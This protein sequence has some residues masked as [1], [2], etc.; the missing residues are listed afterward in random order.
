MRIAL[1][2]ACF[3]LVTAVLARAALGAD[4]APGGDQVLVLDNERTLEG[5][6]EQIGGQYRLRRP[7]GEL[8][9][10]GE[11][12]LKVCKSRD[13]AYLF[14]KTRANLRDPDERLRLARWCYLNGLRQQALAEVTAAVELRPNHAESRLLL[15]NLQQAAATAAEAKP[16]VASTTLAPI[17][18]MP[19]SV[20]SESLSLFVTKV[21]P[22][23]MNT[24]VSCH[25]TGRGG[26][27]KLTRVFEG[28]V[29]SR[30]VTQQNLSAV[31]AQVQ[32]ER[33]ASSPLLLKAVSV[34][35]DM[36]QPALKNESPPYRALEDWVLLTLQTETPKEFAAAGPAQEIIPVKAVGDKGTGPASDAGEIGKPARAPEAGPMDAYDPV[37]FNRQM[38][39]QR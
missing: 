32:K 38:H 12:V 35:G 5:K 17:P 20:T 21:Q 8:W 36:A 6:I 33:P 4:A 19:A 7:V 18:V 37:I 9:I 16:A 13:D 28:A 39:P 29:A 30:H 14:L 26:A 22:I 10:Q 34:H 27:F 31:L 23:L 11:N 2:I 1:R 15:R 24:C 3:A 25:G